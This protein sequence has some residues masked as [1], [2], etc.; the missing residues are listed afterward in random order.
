MKIL[1]TNLKNTLA[2]VRIIENFNGSFQDSFYSINDD[3]YLM[4][5]LK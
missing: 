3:C 5:L 4:T 1:L 2:I